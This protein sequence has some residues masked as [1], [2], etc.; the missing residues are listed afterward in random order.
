MEDKD[1]F[2][3]VCY[4]G[5]PGA[6]SGMMCLELSQMIKNFLPFL[7]ERV[8]TVSV[9][10]QLLQLKIMLMQWSGIF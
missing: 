1:C 4:V 9:F 2:S 3:K 6:I 5:F 8:F 7:V 10:S